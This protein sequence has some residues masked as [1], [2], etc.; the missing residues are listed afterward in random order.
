MMENLPTGHKTGA[1]V[2]D[3]HAEPAGHVVQLVEEARL[4]VPAGHA[5]GGID[6]LEHM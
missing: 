4:Y 3:E 5:I 1:E 6:G 2:D